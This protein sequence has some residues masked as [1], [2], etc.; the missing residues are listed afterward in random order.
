MGTISCMHGMPKL[1]P[2]RA[3]CTGGAQKMLAGVTVN[4]SL[5]PPWPP[6]SHA[7]WH[8]WL[9]RLPAELFLQCLQL[10][11]LLLQQLFLVL[12]LLLGFLEPMSE[13]LRAGRG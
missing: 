13:T 4:V 7:L 1:C 2:H 8:W 5:L 12:G 6:G 9:P 11:F 3:W 10:P